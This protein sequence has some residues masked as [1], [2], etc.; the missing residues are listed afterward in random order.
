MET[1]NILAFERSHHV[2]ISR[3]IVMLPEIGS[4]WI[5]QA[6]ECSLKVIKIRRAKQRYPFTKHLELIRFL[7]RGRVSNCM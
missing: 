2:D 7:A 5:G 6:K 1:S 4:S 3:Q